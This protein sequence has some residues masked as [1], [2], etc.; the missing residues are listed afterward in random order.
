MKITI[1]YENIKEVE[2]N[3]TFEFQTIEDDDKRKP[4]T[5]IQGKKKMMLDEM[6]IGYLKECFE[7][8]SSI[9]LI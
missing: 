5:I 7:M 8:I 9:N 2:P 3:L 6:E 4:V 1:K